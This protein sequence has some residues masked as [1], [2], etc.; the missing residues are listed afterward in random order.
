M[1]PEQ[2]N[3]LVNLLHPHIKKNSIR[4]PLPSE[5]RLAVTLL[6]LS[7]GDSAKLKHAEFRIGK[8]TVHKIVNETCQAIWIA[9]QPIVLKPPS[10][11]DWKS[12]SEEFMRKWEFS[13]C[14]GAIDGRHMRIQA[15]LNSGSTFYNYKQFF[16]IILLAICDA[17]YKFTWVDIGQYGSI[18]DGGVWAN[19]D[20]A[21]DIAAGNLPLPDPT[22]LPETN[23]PFSFVF[24]GDEAFPLSTYMMRLYPRKNLTDDMRIFNY[25]LSRARRTI[26]NAFGILTARW[27]ILHK[28]LCMSITNCE[29][30]LKALV[31]LH[32]FIM[33]GE[34]QENMNNRQYCTTDLIVTEERDG[35]IREGQWRRHF[36]SHFAELGRLGANRADSVA[37]EMRNILKEYFISPVGEAQA[38][39]Q[40]EYT[41]RGAIINPSV[42]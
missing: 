12:F 38:S 34:K 11:E 27:R 35:S 17:S 4:T 10:K 2:F 40:Y 15:P 21:N 6:Y 22:P 39:W 29:N 37:K 7:Q 3:L 36:S 28:P 13:N 23:I 41:F 25:R 31:C 24:I 30:V 5:L 20:F 42:I 14:L 26:E 18:S 32:N 1:W 33:Y 16:S 8:S 9:L 19:T